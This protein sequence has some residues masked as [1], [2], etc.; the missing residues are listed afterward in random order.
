[1]SSIATITNALE[2]EGKQIGILFSRTSPT[3]G[4]ISWELP[5][6]FNAYDGLVVVAS[7]TEINPSNYPTD[8]VKYTAS[9]DLTVPADRLGLAQ[10][11]VALYGD[12]TTR[13]AN[14][15]GLNPDEVYFISGHAVN[16]VRHYYTMGVRSYGPND[17][18]SEVFA[19]D[20]DKQY[21]PPLNP[22]IGQNYFDE[23]RLHARVAESIDRF[24]R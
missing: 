8:S 7:T 11:V 18:K 14:I 4:T 12:K 24:K 21:S 16:N 6:T 19:G 2:T 23:Q 15:T 13:T 22:T 20:M 3:T 17:S 5:S 1:M 9:L 10:V